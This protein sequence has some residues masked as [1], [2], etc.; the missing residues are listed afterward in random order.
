[1]DDKIIVLRGA[2]RSDLD[3]IERIYKELERHPISSESSDDELIVVAYHLHNLYNAFE[4][5][6]VNI[7]STFENSIDPL[8]RWHAQLLERMRLD[9]SP[10]R[11]AV[12]D[13]DA[14]DLLDELRRFRHVFRH[15]YSIRLDADRLQLVLRKA[16]KL[17]ALHRPQFQR[18]DRYLQEISE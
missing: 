8:D 7:A 18:F 6:F 1:M 5:I 9:V 2:I 14:Y 4:N 11:P 16:M 3:T 15:A 13:E 10:L 12:I 17:R